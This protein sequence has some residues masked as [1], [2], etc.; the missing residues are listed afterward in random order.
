VKVERLPNHEG[1]P[2]HLSS[3]LTYHQSPL[4]MIVTSISMDLTTNGVV[5]TDAIKYVSAKVDHLSN[6][7]KKLLQDIKDG[8]AKEEDGV[9]VAEEDE[10][11]TNGIF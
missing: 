10:K 2:E 6:Q 5:I 11:T 7:E 9:A 4:L 1:D 3:K 8:K